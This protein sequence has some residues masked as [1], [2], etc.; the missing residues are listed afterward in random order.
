[1]WSFVSREVSQ[2]DFLPQVDRD[3]ICFAHHDLSHIVAFQELPFEQIWGG[4]GLPSFL[5]QLQLTFN[6]ILY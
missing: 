4:A 6:I 3:Y 1:M 5:F 2:L